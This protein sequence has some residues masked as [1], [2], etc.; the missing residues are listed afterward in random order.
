MSV[1]SS[2]GVS[3][4]AVGSRLHNCRFDTVSECCCKS[5]AQMSSEQVVLVEPNSAHVT[6]TIPG[7]ASVYVKGDKLV[8][9]SSLAEAG[10]REC[11]S[12]GAPTTSPSNASNGT[13]ISN[14]CSSSGGPEVGDGCSLMG[15]GW[16][17]Q[18]QTS[19]DTQVAADGN[20]QGN[21]LEDLPAGMPK[22]INPFGPRH[23]RL[24]V[25]RVAYSRCACGRLCGWRF[26]EDL[27]ETA[28]TLAH[29]DIPEDT[30]SESSSSAQTLS[31]EERQR[32]IGCYIDVE[33]EGD[34]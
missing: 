21:S 26:F 16:V 5:G 4:A 32:R 10:P 34:E 2:K 11:P 14:P 27:G 33:L 31:R 17:K 13:G 3:N 18:A 24:R 7:A 29:G 12:T 20:T 19:D 6:I 15:F 9:G 30:A 22:A 23:K 28:G 1:S 8:I 25:K